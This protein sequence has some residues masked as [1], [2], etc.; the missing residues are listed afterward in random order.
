[1]YAYTY[2]HSSNPPSLPPSLPT[3]L[4]CDTPMVVQMAD[5]T[6]DLLVAASAMDLP[7]MAM[8]N[9][10]PMTAPVD[11]VDLLVAAFVMDLPQ[12]AMQMAIPITAPVDL[13]VDLPCKWRLQ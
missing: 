5:L 1:M 3:Y 13:A 12:M 2:L 11:P 4:K 7:Q 8:Q 10:I 6:V 9:A